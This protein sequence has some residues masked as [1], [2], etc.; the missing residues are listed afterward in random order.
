MLTNEFPPSVYG[1]AGVHVAE[2]TNALRGR[3][4][5]DIRT[6]GDQAHE[7]P[8]YRV[9]GYPLALDVERTPEPLRPVLSAFG[10]N[11]AMAADPPAA[12]LVHCHTWYT[13]L[14]G[15]VIGQ[16]YGLPLVVTVHSLEP[17]RPWK[18]EQ[19][20]TGYDASAW[21]ERQALEQADAVIA[22]SDAARRDVLD[23]F[24]VDP[25]R[26]YVV[27][28]GI[29]VV[30]FSPDPGRDALAR[31]QVDSAAPY[32]LFV[33]RVTRQ[34]GIMT[35]VNA[36]PHLDPRIG[37]VMAA[38]QPD[39][40]ELAAEVQAGVAEARAADPTRAI[41]LIPEVLDRTSLRQ[42]YTHAAVFA[43]PSVYEPFGI[44]NLEAMACGAPVVAT[45][46]G[47]IPEVVVHGRTGLLVDVP[48]DGLTDGDAAV[49][50][51][52]AAAINQ[53]VGD[54]ARRTAMG[55]AGRQRTVE[56]FGWAEVARRTMAVYEAVVA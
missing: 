16:A 46:V 4:D 45:R 8:G 6:F 32:V 1:G 39:T 11:L 31:Y 5:L 18:R 27:H 28:N 21:V 2:L 22:V 51:A 33:G 56:D 3:V 23:H 17:L 52:L 13:H 43:C 9:L 49:A 38:G 30:A 55:E 26:V 54:P 53:L 12:D 24:D 44:T 20:G 19:L 35:L 25:A 7:E 50:E 42:L 10:R 15:L 14:G 48:A 34:K 29:D 36:I 40:P 41:R 37:V 47:G